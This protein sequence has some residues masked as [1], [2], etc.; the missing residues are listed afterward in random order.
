M[1]IINTNFI[2]LK[3]IRG[4]NYYD[5]RGYFR[6]IFKKKFFKN[7]KFKF[8]CMSKS[9]KN[10]IR[11]LHIQIRLK[12][13]LIVSVIKGEIFDVALDLRK[14]S[15]TYGEY[16]SI[17]LSGDNKTMFWIPP[18]FA[19]GFST[20][21]NDTIFAYKCSGIYN[22]ES[23]GSLMWN[24]NMLNIDWQIDNPLISE[25]D[26]NSELFTNFNSQF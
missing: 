9:K 10:V 1:K 19:H 12:Q 13:D 20:L 25:K 7:H 4:Q 23:E 14:K 8:W 17:E 2:G 16:F 11:G 5:N 18:G 22:K 6:E 26:Q 3:K 15:S 21:E 24:D